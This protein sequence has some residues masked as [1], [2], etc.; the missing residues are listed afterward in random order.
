MVFDKFTQTFLIIIHFLFQSKLFI[1]VH[2]N[3]TTDPERFNGNS[4]QIV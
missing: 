3:P 4:M 1:M 2:H